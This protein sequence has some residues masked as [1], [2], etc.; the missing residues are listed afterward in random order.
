MQQSPY[1][2]ERQPI[3]FLRH[4]Q[5]FSRP[6]YAKWVD[7]SFKPDTLFSNDAMEFGQLVRSSQIIGALPELPSAASPVEWRGQPGTRAPHVWIMK[8]DVRMSTLDLFGRDFVLLTANRTWSE[9]VKALSLSVIQVDAD[10]VF[11]SEISFGDVFGVGA[12]GGTL[13]TP[14]GVVAW[15]TRSVFN[16][17]NFE[18]IRRLVGMK[19]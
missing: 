10:I 14:D 3:G 4:Q 17:D 16:E 6:D 12:Q 19:R 2:A 18:E 5:T 13:V 9:G 8:G 11:S 7:A 1:S 15:R